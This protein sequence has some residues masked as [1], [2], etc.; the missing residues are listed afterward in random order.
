MK[1]L[2]NLLLPLIREAGKIMT[3]A[4][5]IEGA[6]SEKG[7]DAANMVTVYDVAVQNFL[8]NEISKIIPDAFFFA[9]EKENNAEDLMRDYCFVIDPIDGTT[10]FVHDYRYSC[11]SV[12]M[13]S[14]GDI[15]FA[16]VYDPYADEMFSATKG[17]GAFLN[18]KPM[19]VSD[20][21]MPHSILAFGTCP[22]MKKEMG[23]QSF[24]LAYAVYSEC[25]DVRR[26]GAAALDIA[27]LAAGRN[28]IFFELLLS[29]WDC[30][31][32][33]LLVRE[34]GGIIKNAEGTD[35]DFS[36][37]SPVL[38]ANPRVWD[39]FFGIVQKILGK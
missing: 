2:E 25:S 23:E 22:H 26:P 19:R 13:F 30:A 5:D 27:H 33:S 29:P 21:D 16:A 35:I 32:G 7:G 36:A 37:P 39:K 4:R 24:R 14:H 31:A 15:K 28:D 9:E 17:G 18:G 20:R 34:A 3:G 11:I 8:M 38:A 12:A 10:N 6:V 1:N